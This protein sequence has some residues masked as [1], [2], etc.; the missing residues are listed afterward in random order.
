MATFGKEFVLGYGSIENF[1]KADG[2]YLIYE[3][4]TSY[5]A[6]RKLSD[7]DAILGLLHKKGGGS[8]VW[9]RGKSIT[10]PVSMSREQLIAEYQRVKNY[11]P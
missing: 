4:E 1:A 5:Y 11:L 10:A 2:C 7:A 8:L 9:E 3:D 6:V